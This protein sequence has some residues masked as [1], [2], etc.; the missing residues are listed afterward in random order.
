LNDTITHTISHTAM[1]KFVLPMGIALAA[2]LACSKAEPDA[3]PAPLETGE[4]PSPEEQA[5]AIAADPRLLLFDLQTALEGVHETRGSYPTS[6][7][8]R[9]EDQWSLQ[10]AALDAAFSAWSYESDGASYRLS[11]ES[12]GKRIE[13]AS[14]Q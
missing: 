14:P 12:S 2:L 13:I 6:S 1:K 11:G 4:A 3:G 9:F 8:F 5:Q 10:R 7:E